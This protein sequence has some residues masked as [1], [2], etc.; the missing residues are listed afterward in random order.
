MLDQ[1]VRITGLGRPL[2][3]TSSIFSRL[4][5]KSEPDIELVSEDMPIKPILKKSSKGSPGSGATIQ[6]KAAKS[7]KVL[8]VKKVPIKMESDYSYDSD[9]DDV[10]MDTSGDKIVS[11]ASEAEVREIAPRLITMKPKNRLSTSLIK[12]R[13]VSGMHSDRI[14]RTAKP[15]K[16]KPSPTQ[17]KISPKKA[18]AIRMKSDELLR[19]DKPVHSRLGITPV[20]SGLSKL[21]NRI[22]R[23]SLTS[24]SKAEPSPSLSSPSSSSSSSRKKSSSNKGGSVFER[25]GFAR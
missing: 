20:R 25:L 4:G 1:K 21:T 18:Q 6:S 11:F 10:R 9:D 12:S 24:S 2:T 19:P 17:L 16:L 23:V 13:A 7:Q 14:H 22:G 15:V 3:S 8:L 5:G